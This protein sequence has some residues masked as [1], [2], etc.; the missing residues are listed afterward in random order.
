MDVGRAPQGLAPV[1]GR[2]QEAGATQPRGRARWR[3]QLCP[4]AFPQAN[5]LPELRQNALTASDLRLPQPLLPLQTA[6]HPSQIHP[7]LPQTLTS[8]ALCSPA[9][10]HPSAGAG[11]SQGHLPRAAQQARIAPYQ[12]LP[13][14]HPPGNG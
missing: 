7:G 2:V 6:V 5:Q 12:A 9:L 10:P 1:S 8:P 4:A 13:D 14:G 11:A 3:A